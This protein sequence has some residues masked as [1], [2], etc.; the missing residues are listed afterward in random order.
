MSIIFYFWMTYLTF[1]GFFHYITSLVFF[2]SSK[3]SMLMLQINL[4]LKFN[5]FNV[6]MDVNSII[7]HYSIILT[8]MDLMFVFHAL[9]HLKKNGKAES[10]IHT[11][12]NSTS[13]IQASLLPKFWVEEL[14]STVHTFNLLPTT[15]LNFETPFEILFGITPSYS[16]LSRLWMSLLSQHICNRYI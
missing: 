6:T 3:L 9:I 16:H 10:T 13:L 14:H 5:S 12:N 1:Y 7:N 4:K 2:L 11:I 15:T 8:Q